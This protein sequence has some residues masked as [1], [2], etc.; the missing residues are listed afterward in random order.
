VYGI[1]APQTV[2]VRNDLA[3]NKLKIMPVPVV[4]STGGGAGV[5]GIF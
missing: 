4:T 1:A 2:F 5:V 3:E